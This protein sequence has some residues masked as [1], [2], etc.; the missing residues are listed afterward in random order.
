M[1]GA[2]YQQAKALLRAYEALERSPAFAELKYQME[3]ENRNC[4]HGLRNRRLPVAE[5]QEFQEGADLTDRLLA[6]VPARIAELRK[7]TQLTQDELAA[8]DLTEDPEG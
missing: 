1:N 2:D 6:Y 5:R 4:I 7:S 3:H 8:L